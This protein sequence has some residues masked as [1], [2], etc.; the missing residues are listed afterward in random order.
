MNYATGVTLLRSGKPLKTIVYQ[1]RK[2]DAVLEVDPEGCE[3]NGCSFVVICPGCRAEERIPTSRFV[4]TD[5][6]WEKEWASDP[7]TD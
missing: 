1:C 6:G 2:C 3:H 5:E 7:E 4:Q